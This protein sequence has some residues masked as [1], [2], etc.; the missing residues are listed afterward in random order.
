MTK[1]QSLKNLAVLINFLRLREKEFVFIEFISET[2]FQAHFLGESFDPFNPELGLEMSSCGRPY[3]QIYWDK[4]EHEILYYIDDYSDYWYDLSVNALQSCML[5]E[6]PREQ[7]DGERVVNEVLLVLK[8][9]E[10]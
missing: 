10:C 8:P 2:K 1:E 9:K 7:V 5:S 3:A 4:N 6:L